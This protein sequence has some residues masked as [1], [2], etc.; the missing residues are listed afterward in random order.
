M[1]ELCVT[2]S[3]IIVTLAPILFPH[4]H[5]IYIVLM[6][7]SEGSNE[8]ALC[9]SVAR[10]GQIPAQSGNTAVWTLTAVHCG[11]QSSTR[12]LRPDSTSTSGRPPGPMESYTD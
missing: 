6:W 11:Q 8:T 4:Q 5:C 10:L 2:T 3:T 9:V 1:V 12:L 7:A